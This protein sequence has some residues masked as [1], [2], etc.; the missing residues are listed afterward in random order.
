MSLVLVENDNFKLKY[1]LIPQTC[2]KS[3]VE[4]KKS[5]KSE[6][7]HCTNESSLGFGFKFQGL[8]EILENQP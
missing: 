5:Y 2:G 6:E 8:S 3:G 4:N 7:D 1:V